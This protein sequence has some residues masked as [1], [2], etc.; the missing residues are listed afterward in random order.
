M[1]Y[2]Q[3][4][5]DVILKECEKVETETEEKQ[6]QNQTGKF[7]MLPIHAACQYHSYYQVHCQISS[8]LQAM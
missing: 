5:Q 4:K 8:L 1:Q 2:N 3:L 7:N 6:S